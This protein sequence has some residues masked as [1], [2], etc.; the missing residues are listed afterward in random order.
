MPDR[1]E[2]LRK[3]AVR[4]LESAARSTDPNSRAELIR[5]ADKLLELAK[6]AR[7]DF[8]PVLE[9]FTN[10]MKEPSEPV[11]QQQQ[12]IQPKKVDE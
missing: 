2:D 6:S 10:M 5:L 7:A 8:G 1:S 3:E 12:Q 11:A 4:C 9:A